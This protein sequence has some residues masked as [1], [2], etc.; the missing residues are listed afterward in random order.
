M[1]YYFLVP[2]MK[3]NSNFSVLGVTRKCSFCL[4]LINSNFFSILEKS[5][6]S[7]NNTI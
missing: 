5:N 1:I 6:A 7:Y 2:V 3:T 4:T